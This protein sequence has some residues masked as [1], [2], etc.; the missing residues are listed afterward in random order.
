[1]PPVGKS[2]LKSKK[3]GKSLGGFGRNAY[4]CGMR[5]DELYIITAVNRL[6]GEREELSCPMPQAAAEERLERE[7]T[8]RAR[9][10][11]LPWTHL[12]AEPLAAVRRRRVIQLTIKFD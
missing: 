8:A 4:L 6:T 10:R 7:R 2:G 1:M 11:H 9:Q 3:V 5:D 12:K